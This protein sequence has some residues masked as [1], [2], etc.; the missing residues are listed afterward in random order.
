MIPVTLAQLPEEVEKRLRGTLRV[1]AGPALRAGAMA[2]QARLARA[3]PVYTGMLKAGWHVRQIPGT[4]PGWSTENS[5]PYMGIIE[6]GARPHGVSR[7]GIEALT[8]WFQLKGVKPKKPSGK[9]RAHAPRSRFRKMVARFRKYF[10]SPQGGGGR[11]GV[12][13][14]RP[15]GLSAD[16]ARA[17]AFAFAARLKKHGWPGT[18]FVERL[19]PTM[20][21]LARAEVRRHLE[22]YARGKV[23]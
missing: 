19:L 16:E 9:S 5:V 13:R 14:R 6:K 2:C 17:A 23:Q 8:R 7:E 3:T 4:E 21:G 10:G 15:A 20:E 22:K 12:T 18:H 11:P 1:I